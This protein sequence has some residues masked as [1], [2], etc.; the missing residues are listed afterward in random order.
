MLLLVAL[1]AC[2][3]T[4]EPTPAPDAKVAAPATPA[5][6]RP[7]VAIAARDTV[8]GPPVPY[9]T[10][11]VP[12]ASFTMGSLPSQAG[13][14][15][16]EETHV[17]TISRAFLLGKG[18]VTQALWD[19]VMAHDP[20]TT[21]DPTL[22]VNQVA[23]ID[24]VAFANA[25]SKRDGFT[26]AYTIAG[27]DVT[28]DATANGWRLPTETE[29]EFAARG[30]AESV[31]LYAGSGVIEEVAWTKST[32]GNRV[33]APCEKAPNQ[34]GLC[35]MSGNVREWTWDRYAPYPSMPEVDPQ[36]PAS[37]LQRTLRGGAYSDQLDQ[38]RVSNRNRGLPGVRFGVNGFRLA[39]NA[40]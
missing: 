2:S 26:P 30:S 40:P 32:S 16:D 15:D 14:D 9:E 5:K 22:P 20:S 34:L 17:V 8:E 25:L 31:H 28:W 11:T 29:W 10:V 1:L 6:L 38:A 7:G 21:P 12:A 27:D 3:G 23:W 24:A 39:R 19:Q 36:G 4:V 13:R 37:G 35:D 33:H 18:E